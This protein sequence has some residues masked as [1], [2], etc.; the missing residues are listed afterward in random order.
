VAEDADLSVGSPYFEVSMIGR[1]P[2]VDDDLDVEHALAEPESARRLLAAMSGVTL[3]G[4]LQDRPGHQRVGLASD[5]P[6][7]C[8][9]AEAGTCAQHVSRILWRMREQYQSGGPSVDFYDV[10]EV[11]GRGHPCEGDVEFY[12]KQAGRTGGPVLDLGCGTGRI[13]MPLARAGLQVVGLDRSLHMLRVARSKVTDDDD[14]TFVR[15]NMARFNLGRRFRF[16]LIAYRAFQHL[17]TPA[18]QRSCLQRVHR[19]LIAGGR[20]V[21]HLFDPRLEFC[22]PGSPTLSTRPPGRD[23]KSGRTVDVAVVDRQLDPLT[24]TFSERWVWT[25]KD[26][27]GHVIEEV[28]DTLVLRWTYRYEMAYLF[29]LTGFR[30]RACYSDFFGSPPRYGAE[31]V[32]VVEKR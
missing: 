28:P 6:R 21:V 31:Q 3:D 22:Y 11:I 18:E 19:H 8:L 9:D 5:I 15:G 2:L 20:F 17:L 14:V 27:A 30:V 26:D 13:A 24:Q 10:R 23:A 32:W 29:E 16:M 12:V 7:T 4:H 1:E 25:V